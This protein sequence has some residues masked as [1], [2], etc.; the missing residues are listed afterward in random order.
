M[1]CHNRF[2]S[3]DSQP[4]ELMRP[5]TRYL[6]MIKPGSPGL[7]HNLTL[8]RKMHCTLL[9]QS[10]CLVN[11]ITRKQ[12]CKQRTGHNEDCVCQTCKITRAVHLACLPAKPETRFSDLFYVFIWY[13]W[14]AGANWQSF[15]HRW[16]LFMWCRL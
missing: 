12:M 7:T 9:R 1:S 4:I 16:L 10:C 8:V 2:L 15:A 13:V 3:S 5:T 11:F 14:E 6:V